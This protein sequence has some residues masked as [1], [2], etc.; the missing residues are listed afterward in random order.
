MDEL[1]EAYKEVSLNI[2]NLEKT[3]TEKYTT[4]INQWEQNYLE[5]KT[6]IEE[7]LPGARSAGLVHAFKE[8]IDDE[9]SE[10]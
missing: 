1:N 3:T 9:E 5:L 4:K 10:N 6:K 8:K 7:L 2:E